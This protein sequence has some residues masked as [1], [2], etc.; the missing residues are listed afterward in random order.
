MIQKCI[1]MASNI[2]IWQFSAA[3]LQNTV[4]KCARASVTA[5]TAA[6]GDLACICFVLLTVHF[7]VRL[8]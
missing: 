8:L 7:V 6:N 1:Y 4:R 5:N 2:V 3:T